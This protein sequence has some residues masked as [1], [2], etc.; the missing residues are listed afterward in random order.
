MTIKWQKMLRKVLR[1]EIHILEKQLVLSASQRFIRHQCNVKIR[2]VDNSKMAIRISAPVIPIN[3]NGTRH[4]LLRKT[5]KKIN[6]SIYCSQTLSNSNER[7]VP[8]WLIWIYWKRTAKASIV[9][10]WS[11]NDP[12][13]LYQWSDALANDF[14]W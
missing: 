11:H 10:C 8:V 9:W 1:V 12:F 14:Y 5:W 6:C 13:L 3:Q 2:L 4:P 7:H